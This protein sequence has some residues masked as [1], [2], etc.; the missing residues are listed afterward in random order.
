MALFS[1][2]LLLGIVVAVIARLILLW[3][4]FGRFNKGSDTLLVRLRQ[5]YFSTT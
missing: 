2:L 1:I 3:G 4:R 5:R